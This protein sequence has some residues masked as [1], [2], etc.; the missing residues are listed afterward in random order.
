MSAKRVNITSLLSTD[1]AV[2]LASLGASAGGFLFTF[3]LA[4]FAEPAEYAEFVRQFSLASFLCFP[5]LFGYLPDILRRHSGSNGALK[6]IRSRNDQL[7]LG[8]FSALALGIV[9]FGPAVTRSLLLNPL[10]LAALLLIGG[11]EAWL[12]AHGPNAVV[13][14][15]RAIAILLSIAGF[16]LYSVSRLD[17]TASS[18]LV[19]RFAPHLVLFAAAVFICKNATHLETAAHPNSSEITGTAISQATIVA[20]SGGVFQYAILVVAQG[21]MQA[22]QFVPFSL[23]LTVSLTACLKIVE[24]ALFRLYAEATTTNLAKVVHKWLLVELFAVTIA[25]ELVVRFAFGSGISWWTVVSFGVAAPLA[26]LAHV[27]HSM[28]YVI[29]RAYWQSLLLFVG[30]LGGL[31]LYKVLPSAPFVDEAFYVIASV[32]YLVCVVVI[33]RA[34]IRQIK[35]SRTCKP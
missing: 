16:A 26:A 5:F 33:H 32:T 25:I 3:V 27:F 10:L 2:K 9:V 31:L 14:H 35:R 24:P 12:R 15:C 28:L 21:R 1:L 22:E 7:F 23:L 20:L 34:F 30:L 6:F 11:A 18:A 17:L 13:F 29:Y 4:R 19:L 8:V